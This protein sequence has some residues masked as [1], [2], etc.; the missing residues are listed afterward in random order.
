MCV[1]NTDYLPAGCRHWYH[2]ILFCDRGN[3]TRQ[4]CPKIVHCSCL[5]WNQ[6]LSTRACYFNALLLCHNTTSKQKS[7]VSHM[8]NYRMSLW[9][10][11]TLMVSQNTSHRNQTML[12]SINGYRPSAS[13]LE[14]V[15]L[16]QYDSLTTIISTHNKN[17]TLLYYY[18]AT[19]TWT[20]QSHRVKE[21]PKSTWKW[22]LELMKCGQ[23]IC[24]RYILKEEVAGWQH[25]M[26]T[27][28]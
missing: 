9:N 21:W 10:V 27:S 13:E 11:A 1:F 7:K 5:A 22:D 16:Y 20:L 23:Q 15:P 12:K 6:T 8:S 17:T 3:G 2:I 25:K 26:G 14:A 4:S 19:S 24:F 18:F 28:E